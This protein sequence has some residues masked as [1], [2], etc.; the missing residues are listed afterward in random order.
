M[1]ELH[2]NNYEK[3]KLAIR[4][5]ERER[6]S[7]DPLFRSVKVYRTQLQ[8]ML[9]GEIEEYS[10]LEGTREVVT[11]WLRYLFH[12]GMTMKTYGKSTSGGWQVDH[13]IPLDL[14]YGQKREESPCYSIVKDNPDSQ[15]LIF[16]WYNIQPLSFSANRT[17]SN[18]ITRLSIAQHLKSLRKFFEECDMIERDELYMDYRRF[19][20][21]IYKTLSE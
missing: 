2:R 18:T 5:K 17:K 1:A 13:I 19:L 4:E 15:R 7:E 9:R 12:D 20:R 8:S 10:K 14:L 21:T 11:M 3:N 16:S 6:Y